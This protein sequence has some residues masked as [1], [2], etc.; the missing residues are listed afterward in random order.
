MEFDGFKI[1]ECKTFK[2]K[3]LGFMFKTNFNYGLLF[4]NC[5]SI[6]TFFMKD[7]IDVIFLDKNNNIIRRYYNIGKNKILICKGAK[8]VIE[9]P[10]K[11]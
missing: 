4:N 1:I 2:D 8:K 10:N 3:L 5:C 7:N 9:I 6:H 11:R